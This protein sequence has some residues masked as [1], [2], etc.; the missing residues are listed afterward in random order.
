MHKLLDIDKISICYLFIYLF[1]KGNSS[2]FI[3]STRSLSWTGQHRQS[4]FSLIELLV[5][6]T[7]VAVLATIASPNLSTFFEKRRND[8]AAQTLV[9]A[10][11]DARTESQIRRQDIVFKVENSSL[12]LTPLGETTP[13]RQYPI[14]PNIRIDT[15]T[16]SI[17]FKANKTVRLP[18]GGVRTGFTYTAMCSIKKGKKGSSVIVDNNGNVKIDNGASQCS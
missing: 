8:E 1:F 9:A 7:I 13:I 12:S 2:V 15:R 5:V 14:N 3:P 11:R 10:F 4:G 18:L 16:P 17:V 6:L